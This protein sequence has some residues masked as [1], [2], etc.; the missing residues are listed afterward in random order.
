MVI[1]LNV[2]S[3]AEYDISIYFYVC[4]L[5]VLEAM[6]FFVCDSLTS[7]S[8]IAS[9]KSQLLFSMKILYSAISNQQGFS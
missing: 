5:F 1:C 8:V 4:F 9:E 7:R 3:S 6:L 2:M